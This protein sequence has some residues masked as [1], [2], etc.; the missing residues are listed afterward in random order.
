MLASMS[1]PQNRPVV[2]PAFHRLISAPWESDILGDTSWFQIW[3][4]N[5]SL[6]TL[7][8]TGVSGSTWKWF[9]TLGH[10]TLAPSMHFLPKYLCFVTI[11]MV[12][13]HY[14]NRRSS[15]HALLLFNKSKLKPNKKEEKKIR[16]FLIVSTLF[17]N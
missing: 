9:P 7:V 10:R 11:L 17:Q 14:E 13:L 8:R 6:S 4:Q 3:G 16:S 2:F 12:S 5:S 15:G 1:S